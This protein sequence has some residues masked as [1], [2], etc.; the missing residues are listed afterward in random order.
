MSN[1]VLTPGLSPVATG[2]R[3]LDEILNGGLTPNHL[4]LVSGNPGSGKTTLA[5][6]FV[7][8]GV[9]RG[10]RALYVTLSETTE[11]L[12]EVAVSHG[13]SLDALDL[14]ELVAT[15]EELSGDAQYTMFHPVEMELSETTR[16][17]LEEVERIRP[18]RVVFDS[19][20]EM[21]LLAQSPLR[22][23]RQIL[24]LKQFFTGRHCTVLLLDD[25]SSGDNDLQ[26][27]SI[28]HGVIV[29]DQL[30]PEYGIERRR[31]WVQKMRG[32]RYRGGFHDF[33]IVPGGLD[34]Y[35]R[36]VASEYHTTFAAESVS[37]GLPQMDSLLGGGLGRGTTALLMG[38]AGSGKSSLA[39][40][41]AVTAAQRGER[42]VVFTF[43]E[44]LATLLGR[45]EGL[46][47][48]LEEH[49][50]AGTID[51]QQID[52]AELSP[53]EFIHRVCR[54]VEQDDS[55]IVVIDSLNGYLN[56]MP[57]ERFLLIQMHELTTY[58]ARQGVTTLL[59]VAQ[60]GLLR[61]ALK[62]PVDIS[63][64]ADTVI[65][66]RY[67]EAQGVIKSAISVLKKRDGGH[68]RT[69]RQLSMG[70]TG[71]QIGQPLHEF[72]GI[73][74]GAPQF[75]GTSSQLSTPSDAF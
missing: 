64:L 43:D 61:D 4:Y 58:L 31:L 21:R 48:G 26:L 16:K 20:S 5:L 35:P 63:Y 49:V 10:E 39:T 37:S 8:E 71:I 56:A 55:R 24:A 11:E 23:R 69:I 41:Y 19:L 60:N 3:G 25:R 70:P 22:Y 36:L 51:L 45:S 6:Q 32:A 72:Q 18:E 67:F 57:E 47:M 54:A 52:P 40:Q 59:V 33:R 12:R 13:W 28:A 75:V 30:T 50:R 7:L 9:R 73:L 66:L 65:L 1:T 14:C 17:V 62:A 46:G 34:I 15:E 38:P 68:E 2:V 53:G 29:L 42:S 44:R 27:E 74:T